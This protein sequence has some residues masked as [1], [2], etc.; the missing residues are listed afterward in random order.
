MCRLTPGKANRLWTWFKGLTKWSPSLIVC[1]SS[2]GTGKNTSAVSRSNAKNRCGVDRLAS[3]TWMFSL[4]DCGRLWRSDYSHSRQ[5]QH[6][7]EAWVVEHSNLLTVGRQDLQGRQRE[8]LSIRKHVRIIVHSATLLTVTY[9]F[10]PSTV[11][12]VDR[13][14]LTATVFLT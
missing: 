12:I 9:T 11:A 14:S 7:Q 2:L 6:V 5:L 4:S 3:N 13:E 10:A 1:M 8:A